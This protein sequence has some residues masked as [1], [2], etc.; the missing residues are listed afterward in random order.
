MLKENGGCCDM[1][2]W[3]KVKPD[4]YCTRCGKCCKF[5]MIPV[6]EPVDLDTEAYLVAHGIVYDGGSIIIPARCQ[7]L[8][9]ANRCTIHDDKFSNCRLAG[10]K[11]CK[12]AQKAWSLLNQK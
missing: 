1:E 5:I 8:S 2:N 10:E 7:Y 3:R 12:E 9:S 6:G 11:E 4:W